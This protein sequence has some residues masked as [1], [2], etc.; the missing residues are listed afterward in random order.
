M[1]LSG[2]TRI[3]PDVAED[4]D[5][6]ARRVEHLL[7]AGPGE[8]AQPGADDADRVD[9]GRDG[10]PCLFRWPRSDG[11]DAAL[12]G[13]ATDLVEEVSGRPELTGDHRAPQDVSRRRDDSH[14]CLVP[15]V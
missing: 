7:A 1:T 15:R 5:R 12:P 8:H 4:C 6:T 14:G 10:N 13:S 3:D 2:G 9:A 11:F